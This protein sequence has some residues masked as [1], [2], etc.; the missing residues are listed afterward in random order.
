MPL[1]RSRPLPSLD[2]W[3]HPTSPTPRTM[4]T[5]HRLRTTICRAGTKASRLPPTRQ[6][7]GTLASGPTALPRHGAGVVL[8]DL[9]LWNHRTATRDIKPHLRGRWATARRTSLPAGA[10]IFEG[11]LFPHSVNSFPTSTDYGTCLKTL[12]HRSPLRR[13]RPEEKS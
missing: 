6:A 5:G 4:P 12:G 7:R 3:H 8:K 13:L 1:T 11:P 9:I 2:P 10:A